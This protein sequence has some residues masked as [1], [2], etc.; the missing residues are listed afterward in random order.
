MY[1]FKLHE[2]FCS[3]ANKNANMILW[4]TITDIAVWIWDSKF[5]IVYRQPTT[6]FNFKKLKTKRQW[7]DD[8]YSFFNWSEFN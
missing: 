3:Q 4:T 5:V 8:V 7:N 1:S 6:I 2:K